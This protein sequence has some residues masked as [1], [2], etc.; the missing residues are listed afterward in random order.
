ME[1]PWPEL[2]TFGL[3][4]GTALDGRLVVRIAVA[5]RSALLSALG[6]RHR[7][8]ELGLLHGHHDGTQRQCAF[9]PLPTVGR[10]HSDG[11][12]RGVA[13]TLSPALPTAVRRSLLEQLGMDVERPRLA[14]AVP[15]LQPDRQVLTHGALDGRAV[16][17][18]G[19]WQGG[20]AG[21]TT[22]ATV[23]P[24]VLD[25][26]PHRRD[27]AVDHVRSA[28]AFAGYP[29]PERVEVLRES[30]VAGAAR[31]RPSD[32]LRRPAEPR[33]PALHCRITFRAPVRGLVLLGHMR[34]VGLGLCLPVA[35][36]SQEGASNGT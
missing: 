18:A 27:D 29:D 15:G 11:Q 7:P 19:R 26:H 17:S 32:L 14:L 1:G 23:S 36:L 25:R 21:S 6:G 16:V 10:E 3:P 31:L 33:R 12:V 4:S 2:L 5:W 13:L 9:V 8:E 22:W 35:A 20:P 28:C 24:L 30:A 34:H